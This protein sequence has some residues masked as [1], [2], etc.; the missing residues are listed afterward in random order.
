M[1]GYDNVMQPLFGMMTDDEF[2]IL[3]EY[4]LTLR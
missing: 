4:L 1:E 2:D 3:V